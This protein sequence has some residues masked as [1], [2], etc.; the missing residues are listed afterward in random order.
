MFRPGGKLA[1]TPQTA[2]TLR[3][4]LGTVSL[5]TRMGCNL[6]TLQKREEHYKLLYEIAQVS[7]GWGCHRCA[8]L[9]DSRRRKCETRRGW[10]RGDFFFGKGGKDSRQVERGE[11]G[12]KM[13][14][15]PDRNEKRVI[16]KLAESQCVCVSI[17]VCVFLSPSK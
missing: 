17:C 16:S 11:T 13:G 7:A 3:R 4:A 1:H 6:C 12:R 2:H 10:R 8:E 15:G 9:N 14:E 5:T